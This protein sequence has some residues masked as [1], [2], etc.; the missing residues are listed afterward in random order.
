MILPEHPSP[1]K[2][3]EPWWRVP[4]YWLVR[5]RP[6]TPEG[7]AEKAATLAKT[8]ADFR[9]Y[10]RDYAA[11][12][13]D[14]RRQEAALRRRRRRE[15]LRELAPPELRQFLRALIRRELRRALLAELPEAIDYLLAERGVT[16]NGKAAQNHHR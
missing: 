16:R 7:E 6:L 13:A 5:G 11:R 14:A 2:P 4:S 3:P 9:A 10:C 8:E 1:D 15:R 12:E